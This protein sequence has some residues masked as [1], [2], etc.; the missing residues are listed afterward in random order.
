MGQDARTSY[1][2]GGVLIGVSSPQ[3]M[4]IILSTSV[5]EDTIHGGCGATFVSSSTIDRRCISN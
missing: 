2:D 1:V 5:D 4:L 3:T